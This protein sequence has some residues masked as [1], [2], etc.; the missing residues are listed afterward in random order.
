MTWLYFIQ[1][2]PPNGAVKI[3]YSV[4]VE[5]RLG[6]LRTAN[7]LELRLLAKIEYAN[8]EDIERRVHAELADLRLA[9]EWF[10]YDVRLTTLMSAL[11]IQA[12]H[13]LQSG[14]EHLYPIPSAISWRIRSSRVR[15]ELN[16]QS[17]WV[18]EWSAASHCCH[19]QPLIATLSMAH[20]ALLFGRWQPSD[21][22]IIGICE[23]AEEAEILCDKAEPWLRAMA[24]AR[25]L[26][27]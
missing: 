20:E 25:R 2:G 6:Q 1:A 11:Q 18:V 7:A 4:D 15:Q 10:T 5:K 16:R 26:V 13:E 22:M 23:T 17:W 3:G 27:G 19:V 8:A 24:T 21:Y 12:E 9:G 14:H